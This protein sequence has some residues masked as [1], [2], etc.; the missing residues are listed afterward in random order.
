MAWVSSLKLNSPTAFAADKPLILSDNLVRSTLRDIRWT[1]S[2]TQ[3]GTDYTDNSYPITR[4]Y[5]GRLWR[6]SKPSNQSTAT[7]YLNIQI[8]VSTV[9]SVFVEF[10]D[11]SETYTV[12]VEIADDASHTTHTATLATWS[13]LSAEHKRR[14][15][16]DGTN[17]RQS[18]EYIR[19]KFVNGTG[20]AVPSVGEVFVSGQRQLSRN[21][22]V[23]GEY[24]DAPLSAS[25][26][27]FRA[28]NRS[29]SRYVDARGFRDIIGKAWPTGSDSY[30]L[31]DVS[32]FRAIFAE[33]NHGAEPVVYIESPATSPHEA[34]FGFLKPENRMP[35]QGP[36]KRIKEFYLSEEPPFLAREA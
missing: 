20:T 33:C 18:L 30:G 17:S 6:P 24:D 29:T 5:D 4:L 21:W 2:G 31:D 28:R 7:Y 10:L 12:T 34:L 25:V 11:L 26:R 23:G 3:S 27:D 36:Y 13:G 19:L 8:D 35:L 15:W 32:R 1:T 14:C 9:D 16:L 22:N